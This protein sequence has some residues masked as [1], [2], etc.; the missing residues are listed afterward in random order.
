VTIVSFSGIDGAGK[1]T[2]I[3]EFEAWL[4]QFRLTTR[5]FTFWDNVVVL[6]R[7]RE[8]MSYKAFKGELG[9]GSPEKPVQRRDK[10][11]TS[12]PVVAV[13][14]FLYFADALNLRRKVARTR[15]SASE[16]VIFDRYIY[17]ELAN[18][19][20]KRGLTKMFVQLILRIVPKPDLAF[21]I[22]ADPDA[23]H[24]RKPEYPLEFVRQNR[25]AYLALAHLAG[26]IIVVPPGSL[27]VMKTRVR[28]EMLRKLPLQRLSQRRTGPILP[29]CVYPPANISPG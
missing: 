3:A 28:D 9:V 6:S 15:E 10:N 22:D 8:F 18:L 19:P 27:E 1:S 26:T 11:V 4:H 12:L 14:L 29:S 23:A 2:Q 24:A 16:V 25:E 17:D 7:W 13:R 20:L 21:V 5:I